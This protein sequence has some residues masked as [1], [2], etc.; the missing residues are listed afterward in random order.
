MRTTDRRG[1][2]IG[3]VMVIVTVFA[4]LGVF[5]MSS[6]SSEY[7][8]TALVAYRIKAGAHLDAV[9]EEALAVLY[10]KLNR[11]YDDDPANDDSALRD[12]PA[13]KQ[14]VF[15]AVKAAVESGDT[16]VIASL[17]KDLL[18]ED[19]VTTSSDIVT[20][21]GGTVDECLVEFEGFRKIYHTKDGAFVE[22]DSN[23]Y[24][25]PN[26][27]LDPADKKILTPT[28]Y[29]GYVTVKIKTSYGTGRVR[30]RRSHAATFDIKIVNQTPMAQEFAVFQWLPFEASNTALANDL[31]EGGGLH[32][33]P[34]GRGR[35]YN[36]GPYLPNSYGYDDG[37]GGDKPSTCETY[38]QD[39]WHDWS[40]IPAPR[41]CII[42]RGLFGGGTPPGRAGN[43]GSWRLMPTV[44][45]ILGDLAGLDTIGYSIVNSPSEYYCANKRRGSV[46]DA[47][48]SL[49]GD[50]KNGEPDTFVGL[51]AKIGENAV[52]DKQAFE[53][54]ASWPSVGGDEPW[55]VLPEGQLLQLC[56]RAKY[57]YTK[58]TIPIG[59][60]SIDY[61]K[62]K[63]DIIQRDLPIAYCVMWMKDFEQSFW[64]AF[65]SVLFSGAMYF[66]GGVSFAAWTGT[67]GASLVGMT[68]IMV[69][70]GIALVGGLMDVLASG[71]LPAGGSGSLSGL[72]GVF[73]SNYKYDVMRPVTRYY[74]S[75]YDMDTYCADQ[76][77]QDGAGRP[78][79]PV[80]LDG[81]VFV[82]NFQ[83][84]ATNNP[85]EYFNY[86]GKGTIISANLGDGTSV[87][88]PTIEGPI[89]PVTQPFGTTPDL[90]INDHLN[91]LYFGQGDPTAAQ[92]GADI[93]KIGLS[94][95]AGGGGAPLTADV[96]ASVFSLQGVAPASN[97]QDLDIT[98]NYLSWFYNKKKIPA[99]S[100]VRVRYNTGFRPEEQAL[101]DSFTSGAWHNVSLSFR[102]AGWYDRVR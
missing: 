73:P 12:P 3:F 98:G 42:K 90:S 1:I 82:R 57:T 67:I 85:S 55:V 80:V 50:P 78:A 11:P 23:Y 44:I 21:D 49:V 29:I 76:A 92:A 68:G 87:A 28:D 84:T 38:F 102:A 79:F 6:G 40:L 47:Y 18:A 13:W 22:D 100:V 45:N 19:L 96:Q 46:G 14:E 61:E 63:V 71:G 81:T 34:A 58:W 37:T 25:D 72:D 66:V 2:Y 43:D 62:Y 16:G 70:G 41:A 32:V 48:F 74:D 15:D 75:L 60:Y 69:A 54:G 56:N 4:I 31:N 64:S 30:V 86:L 33:F 89:Q 27:L 83:D 101:K 10:D 39:R 53:G 35:C 36:A 26:D 5:L 91:L 59:W 94:P 93:L 7:N 8:Q 24:R 20:I 77:T 99:Q 95:A 17:T 97:G 52:T 65:G 88:S 51:Q 9:L